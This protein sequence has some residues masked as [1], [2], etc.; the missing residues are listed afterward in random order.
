M[1]QLVWQVLVE[2]G[3]HVAT[4]RRDWLI[5]WYVLWRSV[6]DTRSSNRERPVTECWKSDSW[7]QQAISASR[8]QTAGQIGWQQ[9]R[10][11]WGPKLYR[12]TLLSVKKLCMSVRWLC[13]QSALERAISEDWQ[14]R[15]WCGLR[16]SCGRWT[17]PPHPVLTEDDVPDVNNLMIRCLVCF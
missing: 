14:E 11:E 4:K 15:Q 3:F 2:P 16:I 7:H 12:G 6:S 13:T 17:E 8:R 1:M 9:K 5:C 10:L